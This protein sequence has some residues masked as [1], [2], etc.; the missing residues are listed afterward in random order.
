LLPWESLETL[1]YNTGKKTLFL[2]FIF[3]SLL[4]IFYSLGILNGIIVNNWRVYEPYLASGSLF[5]VLIFGAVFS[6]LLNIKLGQIKIARNIGLLSLASGI[7]I[8]IISAVFLSTTMHLSIFEIFTKSTTDLTVNSG[9]FFLLSGIALLLMEIPFIFKAAGLG[10]EPLIP[11]GNFTFKILF[12]LQFIIGIFFLYM[13][14]AIGL[15]I[16]A[17]PSSNTLAN[18]ILCY[19]LLIEG[20]ISVGA[21]VFKAWLK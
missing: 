17:N 21:T 5:W 14:A 19:A 1:F 15:S 10:K 11:K 2:S 20:I 8:T 9:R 13:F 4:L 7:L 12:G 18:L 3:V 16:G 6:I